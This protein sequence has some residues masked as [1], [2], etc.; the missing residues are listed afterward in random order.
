[1]SW[2]Y[3]RC[4]TF[5]QIWHKPNRLTLYFTLFF[6]TCLLAVIRHT[7]FLSF[8]FLSTLSLSVCH[9]HSAQF[10]VGSINNILSN[11]MT[12]RV[13]RVKWIEF[14]WTFFKCSFTS[15]N[16]FYVTTFDA[17]ARNDRHTS[18][19]KAALASN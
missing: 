2:H 11:T 12:A 3:F 1:M 13:T 19:V 6:R 4:S 15:S 18:T 8:S 17:N 14:S 7:F 9:S 16:L 5:S 10:S